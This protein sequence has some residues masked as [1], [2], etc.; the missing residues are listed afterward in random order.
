LFYSSA[1]R[2]E[3]SH[4]FIIISHCKIHVRFDSWY[5]FSSYL[6]ILRDSRNEVSSSRVHAKLK[7]F[8]TRWE[9]W[10]NIEQSDWYVESQVDT[11]V[12]PL[13]VR[14]TLD[15]WSRRHGTYYPA[16][17]EGTGTLSRLVRLSWDQVGQLDE[18]GD[19][20]RRGVW[21]RTGLKI[22]WYG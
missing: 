2:D 8:K 6:I 14:C 7:V 20:Q 11:N 13:S 3:K 12:G 15:V 19:L 21:P 22:D 9:G 18:E 16:V 10:F 5:V 4:S 17:F 1:F